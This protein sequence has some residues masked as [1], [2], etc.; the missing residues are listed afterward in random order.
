MRIQEHVVQVAREAAEEFFRYARAVPADRLDW[1][2]EGI[3][4]SVLQMCREIAVTPSWA[5]M[6]MTGK[7]M[8]D[9]DYA[10]ERTEMDSWTTVDAC[11]EAWK[12]HF[13]PWADL[14]HGLSDD[15]LNKTRWLP[16][17]GGRDHTYLEML[18]YPRWNATYHTGQVA[19]IQT[20]Y[21]DKGMY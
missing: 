10:A 2:P 7:E 5:V 14:A 13:T 1:H 18:E 15:D 6:S 21:G 11:V 4:Q 8:T 9:E 12:T 20:L 3:G 17:N 19:Y 16:Y